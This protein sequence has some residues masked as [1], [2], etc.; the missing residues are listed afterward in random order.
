V[1]GPATE[2]T[3]AFR[4]TQKTARPC[5]QPRGRYRPWC[6]KNEGAQKNPRRTTPPAN[7]KRWQRSKPQTP[8]LS[9]CYGKNPTRIFKRS[10]TAAAQDLRNNMRAYSETKGTEGAHPRHPTC[11]RHGTTPRQRETPG[12]SVA[13]HRMLGSANQR[14]NGETTRPGTTKTSKTPQHRK[15]HGRSGP[16]CRSILYK[17]PPNAALKVLHHRKFRTIPDGPRNRH[18]LTL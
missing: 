9:P 7:S 16:R 3:N 18:I 4:L 13:G 17:A 10:G 8:T 6:K 11:D 12:Q 14:K 15:L 1:E 5:H 2:R